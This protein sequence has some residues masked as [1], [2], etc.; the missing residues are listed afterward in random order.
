M[1]NYLNVNPAGRKYL[2]HTKL[3][4]HKHKFVHAPDSE[5][6]RAFKKPILYP[7]WQEC[8]QV[9]KPEDQIG[10]SAWQSW[11][12]E[13]PHSQEYIKSW[14]SAISS[15]IATV[16]VKFLRLRTDVN[17]QTELLN[18]SLIHGSSKQAVVHHKVMLSK[19]YPIGRLNPVS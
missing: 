8:F 1:L 17:D 4:D 3:I 5:V 6:R 19:F 2:P 9:T 7:S 13:N 14:E 10:F 15:E 11:W 16:D 18:E 12:H